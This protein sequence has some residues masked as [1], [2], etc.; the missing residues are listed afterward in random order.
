MFKWTCPSC[1]RTFDGPQCIGSHTRHC[2]VTQA[3]VFWSRVN[4]NAPNGC[5]EWTGYR[6]K[7]GHGSLARV[8]P[9]QKPRYI[10]AHRYAWELLVGP[11]PSGACLLHHCDNPPC[12]NPGHCYVGDRI[13][14]AADSYRRRRHTWG[15]RNS[16]AIL[17]SADVLEIR[18]NPPKPRARGAVKALAAKYGVS[19]LAINAV[20]SRRS[21]KLI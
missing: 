19:P 15:E 12:V 11:I 5:W 17:T 14:N 9:G 13:D 20:L 1:E 8:T 3:E 4:K 10:L 18:S 6:Q 16:S 21:W 7:F 2:D